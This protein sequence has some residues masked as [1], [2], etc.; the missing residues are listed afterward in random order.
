PLQK[1]RL[2]LELPPA[3]VGIRVTPAEGPAARRF[4]Q[5]ATLVVAATKLLK[6]LPPRDFA[7]SDLGGFLDAVFEPV[8]FQ[9]LER[10]YAG[11]PVYRYTRSQSFDILDIKHRCFVLE[12]PTQLVALHLQGPSISR[13]GEGIPPGALGATPFPSLPRVLNVSFPSAVRLNIALYRPRSSPGDAGTVRMPVALGI[14]GYKLYM[15]CVMSGA[16]PTLQLE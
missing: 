8:P 5:A 15:S 14:K 9:C 7:D 3:D 10:S 16:E 11:A 2:R 6:T 12:P 4:R 1:P 13:K